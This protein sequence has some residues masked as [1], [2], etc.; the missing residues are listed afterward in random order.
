MNQDAKSLFL[1]YGGDFGEMARDGV[2]RKYEDCRIG[3]AKEAEWLKEYVEHLQ[4]V[5]DFTNQQTANYKYY[6]IST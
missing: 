1:S 5:P 2:L 3:S 4:D 6:I